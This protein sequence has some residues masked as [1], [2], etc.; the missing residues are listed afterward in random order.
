MTTNHNLQPLGDFIDLIMGQAPLSKECN[1]NGEGTPFVKAGEFTAQ[2]PLIREWTTNPIRIAKRTDVL[3]C[4][5]G[6][7][8]GKIN[9][10]EECAIGRS[11]AAIRPHHMKL[12]Q[13]YLYYFMMT[14]ID[15]LRS[16]ALGA[17][18][19]VISKGMIESLLIPLL[20]LSEQQRIVTILDD[21]FECIATAKA[22]AE[23]NLKNARQLFESHLNSVFS[24][25]GDG[26]VENKFG[27]ICGFVRGPFGGSLKKSI[28]VEQGF[29]V[30]EQQ[31]AIYDQFDDVRYFIDEIKFKEMRRF[32]LLS[33]D[34]IMSCSGTM[35]RVAIVPEGI[36]RG[37]I[38]QALL[39]LTP[40]DK[41]LGAFLKFWMESQVFQDALKEYAGGAAIQNVASVKILKEIKVFLPSIKEQERIL[42]GLEAI[43]AETERLKSIYQKKIE[44]LDALKKSILQK[45]F[46]GKL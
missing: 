31:H 20:S 36:K 30:Y 13:I 34:L 35:G 37:I 19:T 18:Q 46:S 33:N 10:G 6:A 43:Q 7:T 4:V 29:A 9:L 8:C 27:S 3:L 14:L 39:K 44:A 12:D 16:G 1:F 15:S 32:E 24:Q 23:K 45:A 11:V 42:K 22:N 2:R 28:F 38:N 5:V 21:A 40:T 41:V 17:A 26:W 25:R